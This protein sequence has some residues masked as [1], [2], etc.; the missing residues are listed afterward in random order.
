MILL[1]TR[2]S[3]NI[4]QTAHEVEQVLQKAH[5]NLEQASIS[6][7]HG[8]DQQTV[9]GM[10]IVI[11]DL[12]LVVL[13]LTC[14]LI[15]NTV[16]ILLN[17]QVKIIGTMK[18][19]GGTRLSVMRSYLLTVGIYAAIGT[20]LGLGLGTAGGYLLSSAI[21]SLVTID[22][23]PFQLSPGVL[24]ISLAVGLAAPLL[25]ALVP[26]WRG[27][28]ISVR[29]AIATYGISMG[30]ARRPTVGKSR[31]TWIPQTLCLSLRGPFPKPIRPSLTLLALA[32]SAVVFLSVH[33]A[34]GS[35]NYTVNEVLTGYSY[36][37]DIRLGGI[38]LTLQQCRKL[39]QSVPNIRSIE[40]TNSDMLKTASGE[41][42]LTGMEANTRLYHYRLIAGPW[43]TNE[44]NL[45]VLT[46]LSTPNTTSYRGT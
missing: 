45:L 18:A 42:A 3:S 1:K 5:I 36:D 15:I 41:L 7:A 37:L 23:G 19:M 20:L 11:R 24:M 10:L 39:V 46:D 43:L 9:N 32:L 16:A 12:S 29:E 8:T 28:S 14:L 13:L 34:T 27:T 30:K 2:Q 17:E 31:V 22:L 4:E 21:A 6:D 26:L 38:T 25:A 44:P 40:P 35:I 33:V